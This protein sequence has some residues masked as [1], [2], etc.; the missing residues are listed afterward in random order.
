MFEISL[1]A[2]EQTGVSAH[3]QDLASTNHLALVAPEIQSGPLKRVWILRFLLAAVLGACGGVIAAFAF[4]PDAPR[5]RSLPSPAH[6]MDAS[7]AKSLPLTSTAVTVEAPRSQPRPSVKPN[8]EEV[9]RLK[10]RNRRL[11][12]LVQVLRQ[13]TRN[14][15]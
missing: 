8:G 1:V 11:E 5:T 12:A 3:A 6:R 15:P 9:D 10:T 2:R 4:N 7:A 14:E 13:R